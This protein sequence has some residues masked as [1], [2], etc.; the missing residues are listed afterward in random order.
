LELLLLA[1]EE[2]AEGGFNPL[3]PEFG[4]I[5]WVTVAFLIVFYVLSKRAFPLIQQGLADRE[6]RIKEDLERAE[7]TKKEAEQILEDYKARIAQA[8]EEANQLVEEARQA[9]EGVRKDLTAKAEAEAAEIVSK[10]KAQLQ[11]ERD[12]AV[13]ELKQ[14]LASWSADIAGQILDKEINAESHAAL[15]ESFIKDIQTE[16]N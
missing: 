16:A 8:R 10:V 14:Q 15:V 9:S 11:A 12:R 1:A 6:R 5:V 3:A 7:E 2:G 4:L 13:G